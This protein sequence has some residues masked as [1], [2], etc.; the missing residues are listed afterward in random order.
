MSASVRKGKAIV[1]KFDPDS[2]WV[3]IYQGEASFSGRYRESPDGKYLVAFNSSHN[4]VVENR[5]EWVAGEVCLVKN[6]EKVLW[7]KTLVSPGYAAV[8]NDGKVVVKDGLKQEGGYFSRPVMGGKLY[9]FDNR[10]DIVV[11]ERFP[12][13]IGPCAISADGRYVAVFTS[14]IFKP[15]RFSGTTRITVLDGF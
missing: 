7:R 11:E 13:N 3:G 10:G 2:G 5:E 6:S 14:L 1:D 4:K 12:C 8:S 9:V 15:G